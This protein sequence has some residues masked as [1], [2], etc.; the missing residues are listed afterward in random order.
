[1]KRLS[2]FFIVFLLAAAGIFSQ[3]GNVLGNDIEALRAAELFKLGLAAY[4]RA[5]FNEAI[6]T[7]SRPCRGSRTRL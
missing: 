6:F 1:M 3:D 7:L 4:N 5:S 2:S